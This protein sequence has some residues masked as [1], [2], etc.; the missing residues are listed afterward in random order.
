M[1]GVCRFPFSDKNLSSY[2]SAHGIRLVRRRS[3]S[4]CTTRRRRRSL[5]RTSPF[6]QK[7]GFTHA[8]AF[9]RRRM[10]L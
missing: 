2:L 5:Q 10:P 3:T 9:G 6:K 4:T 1:C 8:Q 7:L